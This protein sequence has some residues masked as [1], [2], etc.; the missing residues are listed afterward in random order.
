LITAF[1]CSTAVR[2]AR[3]DVVGVVDIDLTT[4]EAGVPGIALGAS[5]M[6]RRTRPT[7]ADPSPRAVARKETWEGCRPLLYDRDYGHLVCPQ[8]P[9]SGRGGLRRR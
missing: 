1:S 7:P 3:E 5:I 4:R 9:S 2:D 6:I 8:A